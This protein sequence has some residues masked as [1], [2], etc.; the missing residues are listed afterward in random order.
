[1]SEPTGPERK[2]PATAA[3]PQSKD[4]LAMFLKALGAFLI[5]GIVLTMLAFGA[6]VLMIR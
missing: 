1:M 6:C 3:T 4:G 2:A 5:A